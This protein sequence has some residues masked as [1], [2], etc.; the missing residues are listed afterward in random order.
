MS[1]SLA[2]LIKN[3]RHVLAD[4][5]IGPVNRWWRGALGD[6]VVGDA[7]DVTGVV[8][9]GRDIG[10]IGVWDDVFGTS[11][12]GGQV[13]GRRAGLRLGRT[14]YRHQQA[15]QERQAC[16]HPDQPTE[17]AGEVSCHMKHLRFG[18][19]AR[20]PLRSQATILPY[21]GPI[22]RFYPCPLYPTRE[23]H[24]RISGLAAEGY[25][26]ASG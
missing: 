3:R 26:A 21:S 18:R 23:C 7:V 6:S 12:E 2:S 10:E 17:V 24:V 9:A 11:L 20:R 5:R 13:V 1:T 19:D 15:G 25:Y 22:S 14:G 4:N 16:Q 8:I